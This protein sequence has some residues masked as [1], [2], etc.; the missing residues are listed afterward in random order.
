[1]KTINGLGTMALDGICLRTLDGL[2]AMA[3][4][5]ITHENYQSL[6]QDSLGSYLLMKA[7]EKYGLG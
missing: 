3:S 5:M 7:F 6:I 1:M 4:R 2:G